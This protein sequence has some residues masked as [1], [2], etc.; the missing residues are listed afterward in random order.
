MTRQ[1]GTTPLPRDA[2][3]IGRVVDADLAGGELQR[4]CE[5][6]KRAAHI[7]ALIEAS[8]LGTPEAKAHRESVPDET[9]RRILARSRQISDE[10]K[11]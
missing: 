3:E 6:A 8:S 10:A 11:P 5:E 2:D 1:D 7:E 4:R 9:V